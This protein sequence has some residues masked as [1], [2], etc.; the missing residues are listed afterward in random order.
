M[1]APGQFSS[2]RQPRSVQG[3]RRAVD[4]LEY[5]FSVRAQRLTALTHFHPLVLSASQSNS[6]IP[7]FRLSLA[8]CSLIKPVASHL[9]ACW[10]ISRT[11]VFVNLQYPEIIRQTCC[12]SLA[13][14]ACITYYF[15]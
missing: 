11:A 14:A 13:G 5:L 4:G 10:R 1:P 7:S 3:R 6:F 8:F 2:A 9:N 15:C 12:D